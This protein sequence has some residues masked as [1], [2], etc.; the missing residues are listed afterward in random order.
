MVSSMSKVPVP[1]AL[2]PPVI[3]DPIGI[4]IVNVPAFP[5]WLPDTIIVPP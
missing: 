2:Q 1:V 5:F 4:V 3:I